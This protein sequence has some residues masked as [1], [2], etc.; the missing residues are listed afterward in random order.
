[1]TPIQTVQCSELAFVLNTCLEREWL[2][3]LGYAFN[4]KDTVKLFLKVVT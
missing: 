1:M 3:M 2:E 4:F